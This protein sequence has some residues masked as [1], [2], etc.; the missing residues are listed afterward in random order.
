MRQQKKINTQPERLL[1]S[2]LY[3][4]GLRYR[5]N[6]RPLPEL[7]RTA[8]IIFR[9]EKIAVFVD[10]CFW[11]GCPIH[12][13]ATKSNTRWWADKI[14]ANKQRDTETTHALESAGWR[15]ERVWEHEDPESAAARIYAIIRPPASGDR[16]G[17]C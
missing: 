8:D 6:E 15:V 11:H 14:N 4:R 5:V 1:R 16:V 7:R 9:R 12:T 13:R 17:V 10:G 3:A 2:A